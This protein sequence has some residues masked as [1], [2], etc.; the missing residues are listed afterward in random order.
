MTKIYTLFYLL[1]I[2][3]LSLT[4]QNVGI[5]SSSPVSKLD[6]AGDIALREGTPIAVSGAN[7]VITIS[8]HA[9][10]PENSFYR[11]T[12]SPTG[13]M[14]L[15]SIANGVDGQLITLVNATTINLS[16][17]NN[18]AANGILIPGTISQVIPANGSVTLQY[19]SQASRWFITSAEGSVF[20]DWIKANTSNQ[21]AISSDNQYV[22]G[23]VGIGDFSATSPSSKFHIYNGVGGR[24]SS[25]NA[26]NAIASFDGGSGTVNSRVIIGSNWLGTGTRP[27]S[28]L[29]FWNNAFGGGQGN[30]ATIGTI[31]SQGTA[32][33]NVN[34]NLTFS[35][36]NN[37]ATP[38]ERIRINSLGNTGIGTT[39]PYAKLDVVGN[40]YTSFHGNNSQH[41]A[42][43]QGSRYIG[44]K[45]GNTSD[46]FAGMEIEIGNYGSTNNASGS[47]IH[48]NTWGNSISTSRR[49]M[50]I[51]SNGNVG[52]G[53]TTPNANLEVY[54]QDGKIR[55]SDTRADGGTA[56]AELGLEFTHHNTNVTKTAIIA[57][58][59]YS[60][61]RADLHFILDDGA[62]DNSYILGTNTKM[63]IKNNGNVGIGTTAPNAPLQ[64]ANAIAN[65]K[66]V[67]WEST[68]NDHQYYGFGINGS[69]LRYQVD[70]TSGMHDFY[71]GTSSSASKLLMR[72]HGNGNV[73]IGSSSANSDVY[74][75]PTNPIGGSNPTY[76]RIGSSSNYIQD[77]Y[78]N[79]AY[80]SKVRIGSSSATYYPLEVSSSVAGDASYNYYYYL[81]PGC[82][83]S[84]TTTTPANVAICSRGRLLVTGGSSCGGEVDIV[85]DMR[86]KSII[87]V[88]NSEN[89]LELLN[90]IE[91]TDYKMKDN[92]A[93]PN[94]IYKK[95]IA[96]QVRNVFPN[97]VR[98][99]S[100]PVYVPNIYDKAEKYNIE[101]NNLFVTLN[102]ELQIGNDI[103]IGKNVKCYIYEKEGMK[104][105]EITGSILSLADKTISVILSENIDA[106]MFN[107]EMFV[108][109]TEVNDFLSVDYDALAMLNISATQE[110]YK[111]IKALEAENMMLKNELSSK[112]N[113]KDVN[114][115]NK[116]LEHL[117][118]IVLSEHLSSANK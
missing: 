99:E 89:D 40:I 32:S 29:E 20:P 117:Q 82:S 109:G 103:V 7:P 53:T 48:F 43:E 100:E 87:G 78:S 2:S 97:A 16:I 104:Q 44:N 85:S 49:V 3:A 13:T 22:S 116:Q 69:T 110:L 17:T 59:I 62:D 67:M 101:G 64:F 56:F 55:I 61:K 66:I 71:A 84:S 38:T 80:L 33:G 77:I 65:R 45:S 34:G 57:K 114:E 106:S 28:Q 68:N 92:I 83:N 72:I 86:I 95:V 94:H 6:I 91:I 108:Y 24:L 76:L 12:G 10:N 118:K 18:N 88:S 81:G 54:K 39:D 50:T 46:G 70:A 79:N 52:I 9:T 25:A 105:T 63:I 113:E 19:S 31:S 112:A 35:T 15:N 5:G 90:R 51:G 60:W 4:A 96:Q 42:S 73:Y 36:S 98:V 21:P 27:E 1:I 41:D 14:T 8:L 26:G 74:I 37:S 115:L 102:N 58:G 30:S 93:D 111:K 23:N 11:I 107:N 47:K 75:L